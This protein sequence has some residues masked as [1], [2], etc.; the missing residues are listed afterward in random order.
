MRAIWP[1]R[2]ITAYRFCFS[3]YKK[4]R[5]F[6]PMDSKK[7]STCTTRC[8]GACMLHHAGLL[9]DDDYARLVRAGAAQSAGDSCPGYVPYGFSEFN[10]EMRALAG[11]LIDNEPL[12]AGA[13]DDVRISAYDHYSEWREQLCRKCQEMLGRYV[14]QAYRKDS[15][16]KR[17]GENDIAPLIDACA[18]ELA[19]IL[20]SSDQ[21]RRSYLYVSALIYAYS[22]KFY[23]FNDLM[24]AI[25]CRAR[26][27][28]DIAKNVQDKEL[29]ELDAATIRKLD[30]L[31]MLMDHDGVGLGLERGFDGS[32]PNDVL[33]T[34]AAVDATGSTFINSFKDFCKKAFAYVNRIPERISSEII[35]R[36]AFGVDDKTQHID[37][38][39]FEYL[40]FVYPEMDYEA[41]GSFW[42]AARNQ[43]TN[44]L[45]ALQKHVDELSNCMNLDVGADSTANCRRFVSELFNNFDDAMAGH[46]E[47]GYFDQIAFTS[48]LIPKIIPGEIEKTSEATLN[49]IL[50]EMYKKTIIDELAYM[51][52][53]EEKRSN[54]LAASADTSN[55]RESTDDAASAGEPEEKRQK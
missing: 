9:T 29:E 7:K 18:G 17:D 1:I 47:A 43:V 23:A 4:Y 26:D 49:Q 6:H 33:G 11:P 38:D 25:R 55:K 45:S 10:H 31:R 54:I 13:G 42:R 20:S 28:A 5:D 22:K 2:A 51:M 50:G 14:Q 52:E 39:P 19:Q 21:L 41:W 35:V 32:I 40:H 3:C 8:S 37:E 12:H 16:V 44:E 30:R 27:T 48:K 36:G 46:Q 34:F 15:F 53:L 24:G